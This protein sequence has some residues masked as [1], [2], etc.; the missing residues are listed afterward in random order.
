M[1][2]KNELSLCG[3]FSQKYNIQSIADGCGISFK[4]TRYM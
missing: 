3:F 2:L 1:T 4:I